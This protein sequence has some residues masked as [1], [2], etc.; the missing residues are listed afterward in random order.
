M[1]EQ[2]GI[3]KKGITHFALRA[4]YEKHRNGSTKPE[5]LEIEHV[6]ESIL[7]EKQVGYLVLDAMDE[8]HEKH[9][10]LTWLNGISHKTQIHIAITS[11]EKSDEKS[12]VIVLDDCPR[13]GEDI[14]RYLEAEL[15]DMPTWFTEEMKP[16]AIVALKDKADKQY[17]LFYLLRFVSISSKKT[18]HHID[19]DGLTAN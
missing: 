7:A 13:G 12:K 15:S 19:S 9:K 16:S 6:L 10:V 2:V 1:L 5:T 8:C 18:Q 4:L 17:V 14:S 11:R 3:Q